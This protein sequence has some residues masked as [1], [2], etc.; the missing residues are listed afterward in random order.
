MIAASQ[1][2]DLRFMRAALT[3][4]QRGQGRT[5]P[6]PAV[7]CLIVKDGL[8]IGRGVTAPSGRP[9]AETQALAQAGE[10]ARG[11]TAYVTLEPCNHHGQT[12]PC[13]MAL[14]EAGVARVVIAHDDPDPRTAGQGIARLRDAGI[15]VT[16]DI[17]APEA[18]QAHAGFQIEGD[19]K[20]HTKPRGFILNYTEA[21]EGKRSERNLANSG[22]AE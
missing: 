14:I 13:S 22:E 4:G 3:L 8:V 18:A 12:P 20:L 2:E 5:W 15:S 16:T 7:G 1:E 17:A 6:N 19:G 10:G 11:A 9:H 21:R